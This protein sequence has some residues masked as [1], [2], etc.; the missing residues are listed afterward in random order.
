MKPSSIQAR[1]IGDSKQLHV[2]VFVLALLSIAL[3]SAN[4]RAASVMPTDYRIATAGDTFDDVWQYAVVFK[5]R[6]PRRLRAR[7]LELAIGTISTAVESRTFVSLGPV[8]RLP[9]ES[10]SLFIEL[11][12]S[13][14]LLSRSSFNDR[15]LGGNFHFTSSVPVGATFGQIDTVAVSLLIQHTS[16]GG[17]SNTNPGLDMIGLNFAFDFANR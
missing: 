14:T 2:V 6:P 13:P 1:K 17:F 4:A 16:N 15:D 3:N 7:R 12:F 9:I 8:W 10:R 5:M 11:G